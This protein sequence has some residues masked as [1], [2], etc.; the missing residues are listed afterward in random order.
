M[1]QLFLSKIVVFCVHKSFTRSK[2]ET[3]QS[4]ECDGGETCKLRSI[5]REDKYIIQDVII[6]AL[7][8]VTDIS[9][10]LEKQLDWPSALSK[11]IYQTY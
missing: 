4:V 8:S 3:L 9:L 11:P 7:G 2:S 1:F 10:R 6:F 5:V